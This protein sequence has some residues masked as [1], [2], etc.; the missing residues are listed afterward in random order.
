MVF[1]LHSH[2][3]SNVLAF[4]W[5][6]I[7]Y[8]R[9][10]LN[11]RLFVRTLLCHSSENDLLTSW[12]NLQRYTLLN[13]NIKYWNFLKCIIEIWHCVAW[14][15]RQISLAN[16]AMQSFLFMNLNNRNHIASLRIWCTYQ[17]FVRF[18]FYV[19]I[20]EFFSGH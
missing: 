12:T 19:T 9:L 8:V 2:C 4:E 18:V 11:C 14:A 6:A 16:L 20:F 7:I 10:T 5:F 17:S 15:F 13:I 3:C 1:I